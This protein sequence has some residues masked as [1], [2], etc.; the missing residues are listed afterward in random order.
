M[1]Y[2]MYSIQPVCFPIVAY[3]RGKGYYP[4]PNPLDNP[5]DISKFI[6][7]PVVFF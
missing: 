5:L 6:S 4:T 7:K 1:T 3:R 2:L